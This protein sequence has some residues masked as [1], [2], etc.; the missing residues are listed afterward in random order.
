MNTKRGFTLIELM[1]VIA[2]VG[3]VLA[4]VAP[5]I[6]MNQER[7]MQDYVKALYQPKGTVRVVCSGAH[8][9]A[10]FMTER[11]EEKTVV[12]I[13][14]SFSAGCVHPSVGER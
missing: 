5:A 11:E 7:A 14:G 12:A 9:T 13:C 8:C 6:S 1:I 2:I 10:V 4:I 3:I